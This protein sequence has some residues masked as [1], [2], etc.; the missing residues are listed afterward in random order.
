MPLLFSAPVGIAFDSSGNVE[1]G[2]LL[3]VYQAGTSTPVSTYSDTAL[4]VA[5]ASPV[6]ANSAG[7]FPAI[8]IAAGSYKLDVTNPDGSSLPGYPQ[9]N[10]I[11]TS[12]GSDATE[13]LGRSIPVPTDYSS[14]TYWTIESAVG[15]TARAQSYNATTQ[16]FDDPYVLE[17]AG[18]AS[19]IAN[20][21]IT[22]ASVAKVTEGQSLRITVPVYAT[23]SPTSTIEIGV[24]WFDSSGASLSESVASVANADITSGQVKHATAAGTAPA[25]TATAKVIIQRKTASVTG[26]WYVGAARAEIRLPDDAI[27]A[28]LLAD[29]SVGSQHI[30]EN[31]VIDEGLGITLGT[32]ISVPIDPSSATYWTAESSV[33]ITI[34]DRSYSADTYLLESEK[35]IEFAGDGTDS[36]QTI[37]MT[38]SGAMRVTPQTAYFLVC[39]AYATGSANDDLVYAVA[40]Y[41]SSDTLLSTSTETIAYASITASQPLVVKVTFTAPASAATARLKIYRSGTDTIG[42]WF[43]GVPRLQIAASPI[44]TFTSADQTITSAGSLTLAHGLGGAPFGWDAYIECQTAEQGYSIG[45]VLKIGTENTPTQS[46]SAQASQSMGVALTAD[47][48]NIE[49]RFGAYSSVFFVLHKTSGARVFLTNGNWKLIIKAWRVS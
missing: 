15:I 21:V 42:T 13:T 17:F 30:V 7:R 10:V 23:G 20:K 1:S 3:T 44:E 12:T 5:H 38:A 46:D 16:L 48:T 49:V 37:E 9:D 6:V 26:N 31:A 19:D 25:N 27:T 34:R 41:D 18:D 2:A 40:W 45:D 8:Y 4:S 11:V 14:T 39:Q 47:A 29:D 33:G 36:A 22:V 32:A 24:E 43:S 35:V 28:D